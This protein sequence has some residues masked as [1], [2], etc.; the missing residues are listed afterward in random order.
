M[1]NYISENTALLLYKTTILPIIDYN[2]I[3]Y[4]LL[5]Q[6]QETKLQRIQNRALRTVYK[7]K[8]LSTQEMHN[9]SKIDLLTTRRELHML[10]L[11]HKRAK[12]PEYI[13]HTNRRTRTAK[14]TLLRVPHP[15]TDK[16]TRA[17]IYAGS[18]LWNSLPHKIRNQPTY[19]RFK[20]A[21]RSHLIGQTHLGQ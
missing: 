7:G 17:P 2:D 21:A 8:Q 10:A 20:T 18:R 5:T 4:K 15:K 14:G 9:L 3:T 16:M 6:Q 1:R 12:D 19:I 11:M 13:D